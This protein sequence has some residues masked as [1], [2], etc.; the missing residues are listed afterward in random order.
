MTQKN[1]NDFVEYCLKTFDIRSSHGVENYQS[2][3]VCLINCVYSLR[4]KYWA[5]TIPVVQRYADHYLHGNSEKEGDTLS[6]M[7]EHIDEA[8]GC[9]LFSRNVLENKQ[10]L[11]RR[12][13]AEICYEI[14][15]KLKNW[16]DIDTLEDF[17]NYQ[18]TELL[19]LVLDSVKGF[20][21]AGI[22]Y[23][24]M[25]A[26]D[27]SRCKPDVHIHSCVK[28]ACGCDLSNEECQLLFTAAIE[29]L[30]TL[31]AK[32]TVRDLDRIVWQYYQAK[33]V[34]NK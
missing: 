2:L 8:G 24:F 27:S 6:L 13:K 19:E 20:G 25:L 28:D 12:N 33:N 3:S 26:G 16:L 30:R 21:Y 1:I 23:L 11:S 15:Y 22:S 9:E 29:S 5:V 18:K 32:L 17:Q 14:A 10:L 7:M 4:A 31:N 34:R